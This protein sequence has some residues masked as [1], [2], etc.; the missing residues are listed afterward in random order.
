M[1][2]GIGSGTM[3]FERAVAGWTLVLTVKR[4]TLVF[5][6]VPWTEDGRNLD[7]LVVIVGESPRRFMP[8]LPQEEK[9]SR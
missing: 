6:V 5:A 1:D 7:K 2:F 4:W 9:M 3:D 8:I